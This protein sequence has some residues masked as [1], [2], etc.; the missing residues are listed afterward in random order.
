MQKLENH[1]HLK[2]VIDRYIGDNINLSDMFKFEK[3]SPDDILR[4]YKF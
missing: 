3:D 1:T 4:S 2:L